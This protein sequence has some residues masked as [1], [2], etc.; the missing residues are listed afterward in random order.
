MAPAPQAGTSSPNKRQK[1][2]DAAPEPVNIE[3]A[4]AEGS[5]ASSGFSSAV[6]DELASDLS[7]DDVLDDS[8]EDSETEDIKEAN[9]RKQGLI[10]TSSPLLFPSH[11]ALILSLPV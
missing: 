9:A 4:A 3:A 6:E 8:E 10:K 11:L 1:L 5:D 7:D 2:S